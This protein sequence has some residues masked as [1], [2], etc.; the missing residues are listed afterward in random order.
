MHGSILAD[1][2][3]IPFPKDRSFL[4]EWFRARA[5]GDAVTATREYQNAASI[6][7]GKPRNQGAGSQRPEILLL[8]AEIRMVVGAGELYRDDLSR[9]CALGEEFLAGPSDHVR[10][11]AGRRLGELLV[12]L[13]I[14]LKI[15][16]LVIQVVSPLHIGRSAGNEK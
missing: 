9:A 15:D 2:S 1:A 8:Y 11:K 12:D 5:G 13:Q 14:P 10:G 16:S 7:S 6:S 4:L 3:P